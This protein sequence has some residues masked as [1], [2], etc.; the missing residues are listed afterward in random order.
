MNEALLFLHFVGLML[1]AAGGF[2]SAIIMRRALVLPA[3]D[4]KVLRGLGPIL[5]KVSATGVAVLCVT[6]LIMVWSKWSGFGS[7]PQMFWVKAVFILSLTVMTA[8]IQLTYAEIR[9]G[10]PAAAARLPKFGPMAG[11]SALLAVLF[12]VLAFN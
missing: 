1:G 6:G 8:L 4:A 9:K 11:V 10:N 3:D 7:L 12:A 2:A 5:S